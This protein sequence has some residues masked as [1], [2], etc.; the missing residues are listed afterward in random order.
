MTPA[1]AQEHNMASA[2]DEG[3]LSCSM[4]VYVLRSGQPCILRLMHH[5]SDEHAHPCS[6]LLL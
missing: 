6:Q 1:T 4:S 3:R 5:M 2:A